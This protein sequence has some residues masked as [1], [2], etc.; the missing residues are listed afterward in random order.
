M[1]ERIFFSGG[2]SFSEDLQLVAVEG[3]KTCNFSAE[4]EWCGSSET[5][6]GATVSVDLDRDEAK[7]LVLKLQQW[8]DS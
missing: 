7:E 3:S 6:F 2:Q 8:L 1:S 5:G 4:D